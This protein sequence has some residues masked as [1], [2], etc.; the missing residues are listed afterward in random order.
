M[1]TS[2]VPSTSYSRS[3][4]CSSQLW[5]YGVY[6]NNE[7][8]ENVQ[9]I[10]CEE[11]KREITDAVDYAVRMLRKLNI[12]G[13][14]N[15]SAFSHRTKL[16]GDH[17]VKI[18]LDA[19]NNY[20][21][22]GEEKLVQKIEV[23]DENLSMNYSD[24]EYSEEEM[25][26]KDSCSTTSSVDYLNIVEE[27]RIQDVPIHIK[28]KLVKLAELHPRWSLKSLRSRGSRLLKSKH[29]LRRW[30]KQ[31]LKGGT[32]NDKYKLI[33][34]KVYDQFCECQTRKQLVTTKMLQQWAIEA[35]KQLPETE[36]LLFKASNSWAKKFKINYGVCLPKLKNH[37]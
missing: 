9:P 28:E 35:A 13:H 5:K 14:S 30:K 18:L 1:A 3:E 10:E 19:I 12:L 36:K 7:G 29:Q 4:G 32:T 21:F 20:K 34:S 26:I 15:G 33:N 27:E 8:F 2:C 11:T 23:E 17:I 6:E 31:I 24:V 22:I 16:M 25:E 37:V